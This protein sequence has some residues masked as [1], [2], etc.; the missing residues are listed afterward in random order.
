VSIDKDHPDNICGVCVVE[1]YYDDD[2]DDDEG[3]IQCP[4]CMEWFHE[5]CAG[6]YGRAMYDFIC[7]ACIC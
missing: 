6:V 3:W 4:E 1:M 5:T 7:V 2:Y